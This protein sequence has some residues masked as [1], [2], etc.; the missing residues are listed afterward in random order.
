MAEEADTHTLWRYRARDA[1][2]GA[3]HTGEMAALDA[4]AVRSS[5]RSIGLEVLALSPVPP[6][7]QLP[8]AWMTRINA[9]RRERRRMQRGDICDALASLLG[10]GIPLERALNDLAS[11]SIRPQVE[12][13]MLARMRDAIRQGRTM[14]AAAAVHPSWFD[15]VDIAML[16]VG[17]RSGELP[18]VLQDLG[19]SH[20]RRADTGHHLVM[21]LSYPILLL[22][23]AIAVVTFIGNATLPQLLRI[24]A[25]AH[26]PQPW[27]TVMVAHVGQA[28]ATWWWI[29]PLPGWIAWIAW[30]RWGSQLAGP[31][32]RTTPIGRAGQRLRVASI[33]NVL[34]QLL[35]NG[36]PLDE[37]LDIASQTV[38]GSE[39]RELLRSSGE[40]VRRGEPLSSL[41]GGSN[42]LDPEFAQLVSIGEQAGE[43]PDMCHRISERYERA[44]KR[45]IERVTAIVEP[46]AI[47]LMA[48]LIG[49]VVMAAV[50]PL[51]ALGDML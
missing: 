30:R 41:I 3:V 42:L 16:A 9:I 10:A 31:W 7:M 39:L 36:I 21:A 11:S 5:L 40:G 28:I 23:S 47:L 14:D 18:T 34:S 35:R 25:E 4:Y 13:R 6:P 12:R 45:S 1:T 48:I 24:L 15:A 50:Q 37:S 33:A 26:V 17:H 8:A 22:I 19:R 32:L 20:Q 38:S 51:I 46:A 2:S 43:L 49:F 29:L 44:A 27:L